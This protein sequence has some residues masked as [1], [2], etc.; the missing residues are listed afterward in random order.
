MQE[1]PYTFS[2]D[3]YRAALQDG[4]D[5]Y[6]QFRR[7]VPEVESIIVKIIHLYL[8]NNDLI[9]LKDPIINT[10]KELINNA[11][12]ANLKRLYFNEKEL[13]IHDPEDYRRGMETFKDDVYLDAE[14]VFME[15]LDV[16]PYIVRVSFKITDSHLHIHIINNIP[17][18]DA[19]LHKI[20]SRI[21][22]AYRYTDIVEA[23]EDVLDDSEG[24]GLGLIMTMMM[25][26]NSGF[27]ADSL[28]IHK[29]KDAT[30][31]AIRIDREF[32]MVEKQNQIAQEI[33]KEIGDLPRF[34]ENIHSIREIINNPESTVKDIAD[35]IARDPGLTASIIKLANSAGYVTTSSVDNL[36]DAVRIIGVKGINTLLLASGVQSVLENRYSR[37]ESIWEE[38]YRRAFYAQKIAIQLKVTK[39]TDFV[40]LA[41]LLSDIGRV[42]LLSIDSDLYSRLREIAGIKGIADTTMVEEMTLGLSHSTLGAM[43][44]EKWNFNTSLNQTIRYHHKPHLAPA[45]LQIP[46]YI[47]YLADMMLQ[48]D[49]NKTRFQL[50]DEDVL[51]YFRLTDQNDFIKLHH[52]LKDAYALVS[53]S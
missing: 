35:S 6:I 10:A 29:K 3:D 39:K 21:E 47:I 2:V 18:L 28:Q 40:Y 30:I 14:E 22:K 1:K 8:G 50:I 53:R 11:I 9:Y 17:I 23:F 15:K 5:F 12:K 41:S 52:S 20:E 34:P 27:P 26:K 24:A 42:I 44:C 4:K 25:F 45:E 38:S 19:E 31:A 13:N 16:S 51:N 49:Q 7:L 37:F 46:V 32:T 36:P 48:I 43:V 33:T